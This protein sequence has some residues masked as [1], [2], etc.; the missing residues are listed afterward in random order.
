MGTLGGVSGKIAGIGRLFNE[1]ATRREACG[2][3]DRRL[4]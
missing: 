3:G 2:S 1:E 4:T